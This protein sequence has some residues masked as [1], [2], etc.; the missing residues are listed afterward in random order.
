VPRGVT[1]TPLGGGRHLVAWADPA[2]GPNGLELEWR[3]PLADPVGT[4][5]VPAAWLEDAAGDD[6]TVR[7]VASPDLVAAF[8]PTPGAAFDPRT[9][10]GEPGGD[11]RRYATGAAEAG[12]GPELLAVR[13]RPQRPRGSQSLSVGF[14]DDAVTLRLQARI[15]ATSTPLLRIP[16]A[17]PPGCRIERVTVRADELGADEAVERLPLD[18]QW[19]LDGPRSLQVFVQ[20]PRAGRYRLDVEGSM[21]PPA[22]RGD[23][24]LMRA[25][26]DGD[27]PLSV[28]WSRRG[29]PSTKTVEVAP[30]GDAPR[31]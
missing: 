10:S 28:S 20:H 5:G 23:V 30:D 9:E 8:D 16:V 22:A 15:D 1:L 31:Y 19:S 29:A 12:G 2:P 4:F 17:V 11:V 3:M 27:T 24:P 7:L 21:P 6:R 26:L 14:A 25:Q 13:R 18:V